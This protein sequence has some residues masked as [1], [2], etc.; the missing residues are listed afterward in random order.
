MWNCNVF[1]TL[2]PIGMAYPSI[3]LIHPALLVPFMYYQ[4][5]TFN[6]LNQFKHEKASPASAKQVKKTAYMPFLILLLGFF[7][8]TF[9]NRFEERRIQ[10]LEMYK[11]EK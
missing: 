6:A 1:N 10:D 2:L 4:A 8:T 9:Y 7:G 5:K 11:D 3:G